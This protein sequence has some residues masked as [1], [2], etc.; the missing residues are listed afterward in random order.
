MTVAH[1][2]SLEGIDAHPVVVEA[3]VGKG[4][5]GFDIVGLAERAVRESKVRVKSALE[6]LGRELPPAHFT[7][8]LAP[9]DVRKNGSALDLAIAVALL[10][11]CDQVAA[12]RLDGL[13]LIGELGLTGDLRTVRGVLPQLRAAPG[14]GMTRAV[15]PAGNAGEG[16]L[17]SGLDVRCASHLGEL[18]DWL[19]GKDDLPEPEPCSSSSGPAGAPVA[20]LSEV[21]GQEGAKRA[22]E[23]AA[24][25]GHHVLLVGPPGSGKTML[26]R[27]LPGLL[28]PP[29]PGEALDI[30]TVASAAGLRPPGRLSAI[31]RPFRAPHHSASTAALVGGGDPVRPGELTL[32]HGGVLFLDELPELR[33]DAIESLRITMES[34]EAHIVRAKWRVRMPAEPLVVAAMNPCPCGYAGDPRRMCTCPGDRIDRYRSRVS[35]PL[36]DRFDLHVSVPRVGTR[37]LRKAPR[38]D[39]S[40]RVRERVLAA[41]EQ[42]ARRAGAEQLEDLIA[43]VHPSGLSLLERAVER[44]GLTARG[45]V[46]VLRVAR[47]IADLEGAEK[48]SA[49]HV[50]EGVQYRLLDRGSPEQGRAQMGV[51]S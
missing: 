41:R 24:A 27:R 39:D 49:A 15:I 35:G 5:P 17:A 21:R 13:L 51:M 26:A 7:I 4:L 23:I 36:M 14:W 37:A 9:G 3:R 43:S 8:N 19:D 28:P 31:E 44:I 45:Y 2:A 22:L 40:R 12:E 11:A 50:A 16:A 25:G 1:A 32:S 46:K 29:D 48:L 20:D 33:R 47:T 42:R 10:A 18:L 38:G 6:A 34:G 30:A